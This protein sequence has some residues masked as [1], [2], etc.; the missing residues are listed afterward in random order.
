MADE[1]IGG[2]RLMKHL[3]T[4]Q[5]SQVWEVVEDNSGRHF[6]MKLLLPE[7]CDDQTHRQFLRHEA[8]VGLKL[9]HEN[10]IR[11]LKVDAAANN[12]YFLMEFFPA[13]SLRLRMTNA[14]RN[15]KDREFIVEKG[16]DILKQAATGLA[17]MNAQGWVHRDIKPENILVTG[18][19]QTKLIDF[20]LAQPIPK[21]WAKTFFRKSQ[22]RQGTR[23]YMS[24]EQIR[25]EPLDGRAD[26]YSFA[27]T[28]YE[29]IAGRPPFRGNTSNDLLN[30][31]LV[32][33]PISPKYFSNDASPEFC[34]FI[35]H[36]LAK[37]RDDRPK[38]F[39]DVLIAMQK[40]SMFKP[41]Q[42]K[43]AGG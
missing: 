32:E 26:I 31:H 24:P 21:G 39:H 6:A 16:Q 35:L 22:K 34:E 10:I 13:G 15:P 2:Y 12:P 42:S 17:F 43:P 7:R 11:I 18:S 27:I 3:A 8:E 20:A 1:V 9:A 37:R 36:M 25:G 30:K 38:D 14:S 41:V 29:M 19:G 5:T 33:K 4:G 23:S 40:L 28:A